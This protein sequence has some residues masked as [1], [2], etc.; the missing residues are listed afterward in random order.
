MVSQPRKLL[1]A[2][3]FPPKTIHHL[4]FFYV[5]QVSHGNGEIIVGGNSLK[6]FLLSKIIVG[7]TES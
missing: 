5:V 1:E 4:A 6:S 3:P 7:G 2:P